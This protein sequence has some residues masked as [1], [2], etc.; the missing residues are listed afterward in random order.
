MTPSDEGPLSP[1]T[2]PDRRGE[3]IA[4]V[5][6]A[7][8]LGF[9]YIGLRH[10]G[11][12]RGEFALETWARAW[13]KES[14]FEHGWIFPFLLPG[15]LFWRRKEILA[16]RGHGENLGLVP[17]LFGALLFLL[18]YRTIQWRVAIIGLPFLLTGSVWYLW[19]RRAAWL[20]AF[21]FALIWL[22]IPVGFLQQATGGLQLIATKL[23][24]L[25]SSLCGVETIVK[26]NTLIL[27]DG[28]GFDVDEG[29]SGI[30]SLWALMLIAAAW[31]Y[32]ARFPLWKKAL[33]FLSAFPIAILGNALRLVS[34]FVIAK[35]SNVEFASSTW[36]DWSPLVFFYPFSL[37]LL[38]TVHSVLEGGLPWKKT[39]RREI[40][41]V[42]VTN[43]TSA[44]S[45]TPDP[46]VP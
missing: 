22:A 35:Y 34:I 44:T 45:S 41:R 37:F 2:P 18:S 7:L 21:P 14:D 12:Q 32:V 6:L 3:V 10:F 4:W 8:V 5:A 26:G 9:F 29:C 11:P 16:A 19:G 40:R 39:A 13:N 1:A 20:L 24:H 30:R 46:R 25:G 36:H 31:T 27:A 23:A 15:L 43:H 28:K 33:L 17:A 42:V 38:L